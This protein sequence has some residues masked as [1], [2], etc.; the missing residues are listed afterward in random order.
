MQFSASG[1]VLNKSLQVNVMHFLSTQSAKIV[2]V[3]NHDNANRY[4]QN[5]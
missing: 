5:I 4:D 2:S 3:V 1:L